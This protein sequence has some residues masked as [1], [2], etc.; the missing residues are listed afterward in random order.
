M[1]LAVHAVPYR[2]GGPKNRIEGS[3]SGNVTGQMK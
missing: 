3:R 2:H 1:W